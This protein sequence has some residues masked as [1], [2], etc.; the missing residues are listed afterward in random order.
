MVKFVSDASGA[1]WWPN[2]EPMQVA[3]FL[4]AEEITQVNTL[5][6]LCLWQCLVLDSVHG[7]SFKNGYRLNSYESKK[8]QERIGT[9]VCVCVC[10]APPEKRLIR[11]LCSLTVEEVHKM[12]YECIYPDC[13][14]AEKKS[15]GTG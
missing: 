15:G 3:F 11:V 1:N 8:C 6:P 13:G 9:P 4:L 2:L 7:D 14:G 12:C 10:D 5:G